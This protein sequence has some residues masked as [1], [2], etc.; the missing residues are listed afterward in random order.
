MTAMLRQRR[1]D[2]ILQSS[3]DVGKCAALARVSQHRE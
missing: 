2:D 3:R 1:S